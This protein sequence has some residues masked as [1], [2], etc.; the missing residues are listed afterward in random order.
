MSEL[1]TSHLEFGV[2]QLTSVFI[3]HL[4]YHI[5]IIYHSYFVQ[6]MLSCF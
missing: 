3:G 4:S 6:F 1:L 5:Y 2:N